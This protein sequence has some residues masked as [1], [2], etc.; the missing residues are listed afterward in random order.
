MGQAPAN[1]AAAEK[2][3]SKEKGK[4]DK[5]FGDSSKDIFQGFT[6]AKDCEEKHYGL[7]E[8]GELKLIIPDKKKVL[9]W[10]CLLPGPEGSLYEDGIFE[11]EVVF[12][13]NYPFNPPKLKFKTTMYH[14]NIDPRSGNICLDI[15]QNQ[16]SPALSIH[17]VVLSLSSLLTEPNFGDPLNGEAADTHKRDK[18]KY[19]EKVREYVKKYAKPRTVKKEEKKGAAKSMKRASAASKADEKDAKRRKTKSN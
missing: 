19:D 4:L 10:K 7:D 8:S 1:R 6:S 11:V 2:R 12:P 13:D 9:Q 16:W 5:E 18:K 17:K 3:V 15:L 14:P